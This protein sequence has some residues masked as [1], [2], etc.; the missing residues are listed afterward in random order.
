MNNEKPLTNYYNLLNGLYHAENT[1]FASWSVNYN[2]KPFRNSNCPRCILEYKSKEMSCYK[3]Y[4][5]Y[6]NN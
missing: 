6:N 4:K 3:F 2:A 1:N 5:Q